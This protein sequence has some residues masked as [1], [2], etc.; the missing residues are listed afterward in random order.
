MWCEKSGQVFTASGWLPYCCCCCC[1]GCTYRF[2]AGGQDNVM[3]YEYNPFFLAGGQDSGFR[4]S[5]VSTTKTERFSLG[6][7]YLVE[8]TT[9]VGSAGCRTAQ[10]AKNNLRQSV[11]WHPTNEDYA[12]A[13]SGCS[14]CGSGRAPNGELV[15][16][17]S[18]QPPVRLHNP[19][20]DNTRDG[21]NQG[22]TRR[23]LRLEGDASED[24]E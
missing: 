17:P 2:S 21:F 24:A 22:Q 3:T 19:V 13:V 6:C 1:T 10:Q 4:M 18:F 12:L 20:Q 9:S 5:R 23:P 14:C 15:L 8:W 11:A 7:I 16:F